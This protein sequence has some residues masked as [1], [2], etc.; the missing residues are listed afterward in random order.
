V[1]LPVIAVFSGGTSAEKEVSTG[2]GAA[3][4]LALARSFTT[5]L[6]PVVADALPEG[7]DPAHH[8]VF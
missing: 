8:V 4:A 5:R 6:F 1:S 2:S 7:Y 3:C